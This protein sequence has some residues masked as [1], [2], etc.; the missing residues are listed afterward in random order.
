MN[1]N[2]TH[3]QLCLCILML[4]GCSQSKK[5]I[6]E[7]ANVNVKIQD[8]IQGIVFSDMDQKDK[9]RLLESFNLNNGRDSIIFCTG[10]VFIEGQSSKLDKTTVQLLENG[11]LLKLA[12]LDSLDYFNCGFISFREFQKYTKENIP[13][14]VEGVYDYPERFGKRFSD[15]YSNQSI[16]IENAPR[17]ESDST[18]GKNK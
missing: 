8:T 10:R 9:L 6:S 5:R 3:L 15:S 11:Q 12:I 13:G 14:Y 18:D 1:H 2:S 4:L 17:F 7:G 16:I